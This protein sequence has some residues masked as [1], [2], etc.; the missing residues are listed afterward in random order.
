MKTGTH[1]GIVVFLISLFTI[2][3]RAQDSSFVMTIEDTF[4]ISGLGPMAVG[5]IQKGTLAQ[6]MKLQ[7]NVKPDSV[8]TVTTGLIYKENKPVTSALKG[9]EVTVQL[10]GVTIKEI[11]RGIVLYIKAKE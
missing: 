1:K 7:L 8:I 3:A 2:N 6:A 11:R 4:P 9:D 10:K 5:K